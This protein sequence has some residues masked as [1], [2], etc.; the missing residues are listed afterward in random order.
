MKIVTR[1]EEKI[2]A[3]CEPGELVRFGVGGQSRLAIVLTTVDFGERL[4]LLL[5]AED[6]EMDFHLW[7]TDPHFKC[8]SYGLTWVVELIDDENSW[9]GNDLDEDK[10][11]TIHQISNDSAA[12]TIKGIKP[13]VLLALDLQKIAAANGQRRDGI[14]FRKW[15][16]WKTAEDASKPKARPIFSYGL[17]EKGPAA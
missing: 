7:Q 6:P 11:G 9:P 17:D 13:P 1:V 4:I 2:L 8:V 15:R 3:S 16:I 10:L 14:L 12:I 5:K